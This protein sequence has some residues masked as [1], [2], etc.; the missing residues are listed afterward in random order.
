MDLK[1]FLPKQPRFFELF[2]EQAWC[3]K[4]MAALFN[5]FTQEFKNFDNYSLKAKEIEHRADKVSHQIIDTLN[6]SY[7]TPFDREDI[8]NMTIRVDDVIDLMEDVI[9]NVYIYK[10]AEKLET[11]EDFGRII[12]EAAQK[13][14]ELLI[15]LKE[16]KHSEVFRSLIK[17]IHE[18]EH[19]GD[20]L[21]EKSI[22]C[23]F[24][25]NI[26][27]LEIIKW[28]DIVENMEIITDECRSVANVI[29]GVIIKS[30]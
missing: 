22:T 15:H 16:Q 25:G 26:K 10:T 1:L 23:L 29:E 24:N 21:F 5:E 28:K 20:T 19:E 2:N 11:V 30:S 6:V 13:L 14:A 18:L 27:P 7:L 8:Y 3:L 9:H 17:R 4:E 12:L